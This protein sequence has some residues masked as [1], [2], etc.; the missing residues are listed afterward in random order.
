MVERWYGRVHLPV[1]RSCHRGMRKKESHFALTS[2]QPANPAAEKRPAQSIFDIGAFLASGTVSKLIEFRKKQKLFSQGDLASH[3][4]YIQEGSIRLAVA[5]AGGKEAI[6][7][8]L[9]SGDFLG[10]SC[11]VGQ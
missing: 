9:G 11:L 6:I 4:F 3:V 5:S 8:L 1:V 7:A 10:E 2:T